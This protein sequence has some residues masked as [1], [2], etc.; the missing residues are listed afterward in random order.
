MKKDKLEQ[1]VSNNREAFD[2]LKPDPK[3]WKGIQNDMQPPGKLHWK[4][5]LWRAAAVLVIF[6][7]SY[8]FHDLVNQDTANNSIVQHEEADPESL[9]QAKTFIEAEAYYT[10]QIGTKKKEVYRIAGKNSSVA[11]ELDV[12][13]DE[14]NQVLKELKRD[15]ND[16]ASNTEV[17][18]A[19][20]QNYRLKL[21]ILEEMLSQLNESKIANEEREND[22][23][24]L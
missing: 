15:L 4:R 16:N 6:T 14:L 18:E 2:E 7:A 9:D 21:M 8:F 12:E 22:E 1:F 19:M 23:Y 11:K 13:F 20:I 17:L 10:S 5:I 3:I 24:E